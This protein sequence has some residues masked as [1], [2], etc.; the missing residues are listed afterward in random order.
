[1]ELRKTG[2]LQR[3]PKVVIVTLQYADLHMHERISFLHEDRFESTGSGC[4]KFGG[5]RKIF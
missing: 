3:P 2:D 4:S 5:L 1:V